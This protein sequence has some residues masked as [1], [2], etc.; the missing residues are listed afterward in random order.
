MVNEK[1]HFAEKYTKKIVLR[2][3]TDTEGSRKQIG[4]LLYICLSTSTVMESG[5]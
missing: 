5:L 2:G 4:V 1:G 3:R